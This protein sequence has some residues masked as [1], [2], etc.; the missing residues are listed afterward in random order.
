MANYIYQHQYTSPTEF[1]VIQVRTDRNR[2]VSKDKPDYL[3]FLV[4]GNT[5]EVIPYVAP[6]PPSL[7]ELKASKIAT[8]KM[9]GRMTIEAKYPIIKQ[10]DALGGVKGED[11]RIE[12]LTYLQTK[13]SEIDAIE[14]AIVAT[15]SKEEVELID[16]NIEL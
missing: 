10:I 16:I 11:V 13:I 9:Q 8:L 15:T 3:D 5:P 4:E 14:A 12:V 2:K 1:N 7:E 6:V